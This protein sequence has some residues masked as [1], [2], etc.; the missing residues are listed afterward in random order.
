MSSFGTE[1]TFGSDID[2]WVF[3]SCRIYL[4]L[5]DSSHP[6][7]GTLSLNTRFQLLFSGLLVEQLKTLFGRDRTPT[8]PSLCDPNHSELIE[9]TLS[10]NRRVF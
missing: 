9:I 5:W 10:K 7:F 2:G 6:T 4:N 8:T 3:P 1:V